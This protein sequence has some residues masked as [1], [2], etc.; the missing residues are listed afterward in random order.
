MGY[1]GPGYENR[2]DSL[3]TSSRFFFLRLFDLILIKVDQPIKAQVELELS[4][5]A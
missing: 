1:S 4:R 2:E 3:K 5:S